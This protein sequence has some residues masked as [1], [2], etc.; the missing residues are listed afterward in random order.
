MTKVSGKR[1]FLSG[2]ITGM[3]SFNAA[4]FAAAHE[5]LNDAGAKYVFDPA[6]ERYVEVSKG[7]TEGGRG[8]YM[9]KTLA[10]LISTETDYDRS[11]RSHYDVLVLLPGW[12]DSDGARVEADVAKAIGIEVCELGDV[13]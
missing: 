10:E 5:M 13:E 6:F 8:Y 1:V 11:Y 9:R 7:K 3:P 4:G 12:E 2:P